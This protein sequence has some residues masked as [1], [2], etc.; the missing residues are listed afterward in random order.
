M[1]TLHAGIGV[2]GLLAILVAACGGGSG[3]EASATL[4]GAAG[5]SVKGTAKFTQEGDDAVHVVVTVENVSPGAHGLH[6][7]ETGDCSSPDFESAGAH[8]APTPDPHGDPTQGPHHAGDLGNL[9]VGE[10][11]SGT[12][13]A[14]FE[15]LTV[16]DGARSVVGR[17][18]VLHADPDDLKTQPAGNSGGRIA[19]GV[20]GG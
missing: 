12:V 4:Q 7:H 19:C 16:A 6:I 18:I 3:S 5:T 20:I 9:E 1:K 13:D 14:T 11:G 15:G 2:L 8:F 10:G 17:A